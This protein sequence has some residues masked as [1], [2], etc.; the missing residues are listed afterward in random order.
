[1]PIYRALGLGLAALML[2]GTAASA[3]TLVYCSEG[4]PENF[5]PALNTTGTSFD[6]ARPVF[7]RLVAFKPG[8][9][10]IAPGLAESW[11]ISPDGLTVTLHLRKGVKF[12]ATKGFKPTRDFN[13]DDVLFSFKRQ[14]DQSNPYYNIGG[15]KY[16][17]YNDMDLPK[18]VKSIDKKDDYTIVMTLTQ[19]NVTILADLAMDFAAIQSAEFA[20]AMIKAKTPEQFDQIPVGTGPFVFQSYQKDAVIRFKAN[21]DY[22]GGKPSSTNSSTPLRPMRRPAT[23]SSRPTSARSWPIR[24]RPTWPRWG[25]IRISR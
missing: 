7:D 12:G 13:A 20:D 9:T 8:T 17:Y 24:A 16:D 15:G 25:R 4:S 21:A 10:D 2:C 22:W 23:P 3:K 5:T 18:L 6:A 19:P 11:E 14:S 1:M